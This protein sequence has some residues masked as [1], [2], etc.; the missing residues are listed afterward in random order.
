MSKDELAFLGDVYSDNFEK[1]YQ[2]W[3]QHMEQSFADGELSS[4]C[5]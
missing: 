4:F 5:K 1:D 3:I 2:E